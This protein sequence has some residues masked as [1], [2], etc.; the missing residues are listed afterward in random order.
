M[1]ENK[2]GGLYEMLKKYQL[3][4]QNHSNVG[5]QSEADPRQKFKN[6]SEK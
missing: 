1:K 2:I 6:L 4:R 3:T 5:S